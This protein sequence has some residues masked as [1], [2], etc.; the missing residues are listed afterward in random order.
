AR[1]LGE[2]GDFDA[3]APR[4]DAVLE[5]APGHTVAL[6]LKMN[7]DRK[8][9]RRDRAEELYQRACQRF[10]SEDLPGCLALLEE[11]LNLEPQHSGANKLRRGVL[12][13]IKE[14]EELETRR[15]LAD[16]A[17]DRARSALLS[18]HLE[19][20]RKQVETAFAL[21]PE[22]SRIPEVFAEIEHAEKLIQAHTEQERLV[23]GLLEEAQ[24]LEKA[25]EEAKALSTMEELLKL[26]PAQIAAR[27]LK[28]ELENR[29]QA[30]ERAEALYQR[31]SARFS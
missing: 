28:V 2:A 13:K 29:R 6:E 16:E 24:R 22:Y 30:R 20:A 23:G 12:E 14:Q 25:G 18:E 1:S 19:Q 5:L 15:Q 8:R 7:L 31:A 27:E 17:L 26:A 3:A 10:S 9:Q 21:Y 4:I 11:V